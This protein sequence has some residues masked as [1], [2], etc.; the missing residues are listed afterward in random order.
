MKITEIALRRQV[1]TYLF[2][3]L[4]VI[5]GLFSIIGMPV[6]FWPKF[7]AP[8]LIIMTPY[9]GASPEEMEEQIARPIEE[10]LSTIPGIDEIETTCFEGVCRIYAR[11]DWGE[12]FKQAKLDV[13][14][15]VNKARSFFPRG[16]KEPKVLQVQD[17]LPPGIELGF[18]SDSRALNEIR[19]FLEK[20]IK[21]RIL[22]LD[23]VANVQIFGG[24]EE[25][26][27]IKLKPD[28]L[29]EYG[30][31]PDQIARY[32]QEINQDPSLGYIKGHDYKYI[33]RIKSKILNPLDLGDRII[34]KLP[35]GHLIRL[36]EISSV[37]VHAKEKE[38]N[39][40]LNGREI[41]GL[42]IREKSG[43]NTIAMVN[44][45]KELLPWIRS[46]LPKDVQMKI[47]RDQSGFI[48]QSIRSVL[49]N[50]LLGAILA[51]FII[52]L[53]LGNLRNTVIIAISIPLSIILSVILMKEF[54]LTLNIISLGGLALAV[55][56]IVDASVVVLENIYR[57]MVEKSQKE[58]KDA[59]IL[60]A[61]QEV[62]P[63]IFS[64]TLTSVVVFLPLAFLL[65]LFSVLLGELALT[66]VFALSISVLVA[67]T[68][69]PLFS[70]KLM[71][72]DSGNKS[73]WTQWWGDLIETSI[74]YY[75]S[76]LRKLLHHPYRSLI[77]IT[78]ISVAIIIVLIPGIDIELMPRINQGEFRIE[79]EG[80]EGIQL[81]VTDSLCRIIES[82][83][84]GGKE[85]QQTY[86]Q[87]GVLSARGELKS[88]V[89]SITVTVRDEAKQNINRLM[90]NQ[91]TKWGQVFPGYQVVVHQT[92][93]TEG[94]SRAPVNIRFSGDNLDELH[95]LG[96]HLVHRLETTPGMVNVRMTSRENLP[97]Y[98]LYLNELLC[99]RH[100]LAPAQIIR[101]L[102]SLIKGNSNNRFIVQ[103]RQYDITLRLGHAEEIQWKELKRIPITCPDGSVL[104]LQDIARIERKNSPS[105]IHRLNQQRMVEITADVHGISRRKAR[106]LARKIVQSMTLPEDI[107]VS[108][109][110]ESKA[111]RD[112]FTSLS[113]ALIIALILVYVVMGTQFNSFKQPFIIAFTIPLAIIGVL[114]GLRVF[115]AP[116][117]MNAF[118]GFIMLIGVVV[119]NGILLIDYT[120]RLR[121]EGKS[122]KEALVAAGKIRFRPIWM[123]S[124]TTIAGMLPLAIGIG[125][126]GEALRP[127][128]AVVAGG[129]TTSTFLTLF[130]LPMIFS[131]LEKSEEA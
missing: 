131:I 111:I 115:G 55:G 44:E 16:A 125:E 29:R 69:I 7:T 5:L 70:Y 37:Q 80:P 78:I 31:Q 113:M 119:N 9:P 120:N 60:E 93:V 61:T 63:A 95:Q 66:V 30:L 75:E 118:L 109:G 74:R 51:G 19:D 48:R 56:M 105:E 8:T 83:L 108:Y 128:G 89:A 11:F 57:Y 25:E 82:E 4:G 23:N 79:L 71:K 130:I 106:T 84:L 20:K 24:A 10:Q 65:G 35:N 101:Y 39:V 94:M 58:R 126:G 91:R 97:E 46:T 117:S 99:W 52:F 87:V 18:Y 42:A 15:R 43:G 77:L 27:A 22:M 3:I 121:N 85:I 72:T 50:A 64:A 14:D 1:G 102:R 32:L 26:I 62:G 124:L 104:L 122:V 59:V 38:S 36:K 47:I 116:F 53:F 2:I 28:K 33:L 81:S 88:N 123:T 100:N 96:M 103:G 92:D 12:D 6:A 129:L 68:V 67:L 112:S 40:R 49:K 21:S 45:V 90:Q 73:R 127:L 41:V 76:I 54:H 17:L 13:Q 110:G 98:H 114:I 86:S 107:M 34:G